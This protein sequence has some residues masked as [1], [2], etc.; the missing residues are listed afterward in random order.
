MPNSVTVIGSVK[1]NNR[2]AWSD[3]VKAVYIKG[4]TLGDRKMLSNNVFVLRDVQV[5]NDKII[6]VAFDL[7]NGLTNSV[8]FK[9]PQP[10]KD[11]VSDVGE[12]LIEVKPPAKG[13][14]SGAPQIIINNQN[15]QN[16][17]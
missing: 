5:K 13:A 17:Q 15:I 3:D 16:N 10:D 6:E 1:I 4:Q 11:N 14:V 8:A 7:K 2:N 9:L 12:V